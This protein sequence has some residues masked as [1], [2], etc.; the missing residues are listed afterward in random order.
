MT[1]AK[2]YR[3]ARQKVTAYRLLPTAQISI[4]YSLDSLP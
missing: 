4:R 2:K 1:L 3:Q